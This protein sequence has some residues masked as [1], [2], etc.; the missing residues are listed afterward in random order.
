MLDYFEHADAIKATQLHLK[1][2]R[3]LM[4]AKCLLYASVGTAALVWAFG[5]GS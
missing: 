5:G 3:N 4:A 1:W 2:Q